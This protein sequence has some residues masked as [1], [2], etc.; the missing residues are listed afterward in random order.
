[1]CQGSLILKYCLP[2]WDSLRNGN[3]QGKGLD[4][5]QPPHVTR[6]LHACDVR[7]Q[8]SQLG[9]ARS[10]CEPELHTVQAVSSLAAWQG[11]REGRYG[12]WPTPDV[13]GWRKS[14][15]ITRQ[16]GICRDRGSI[17]LSTTCT[18]SI[19][20]IDWKRGSSKHAVYLQQSRLRVARRRGM[21]AREFRDSSQRVK[22][23]EG[24][25]RS[26]GDSWFATRRPNAAAPSKLTVGLVISAS[27]RYRCA[28]CLRVGCLPCRACVALPAFLHVPHVRVGVAGG[29]PARSLGHCGGAG[30]EKRA[31]IPQC[32]G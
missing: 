10:I 3:T 32:E 27:V 22:C 6:A 17:R 24:C 9:P 8:H 15:G 4:A 12:H 2:V 20:H 23:P 28:L 11:S 1:M 26:E 31:P 21:V 30:E 29:P 13:E 14:T 16:A 18:S 19:Q 25:Y 7:S 5:S